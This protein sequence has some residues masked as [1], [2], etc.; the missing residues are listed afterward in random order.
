[1]ENIGTIRTEEGVPAFETRGRPTS[2]EYLA[3]LLMDV[4]KSFV[5]QK[6]RDTLY[7]I[8]RNLGIEI[9]T[10]SAGEKGWR[11]WKLSERV[12][13]PKP[14]KALIPLGI[15]EYSLPHHGKAK[16]DQRR[17]KKARLIT[18]GAQSQARQTNSGGKTR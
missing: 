12:L 5:S 17:D 10:R 3:L 11:V 7:S 1:M 13:R 6:S 9:R 14:D 18:K 8:A 2:D 4:G 15:E 16:L